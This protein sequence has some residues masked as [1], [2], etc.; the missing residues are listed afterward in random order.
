LIGANLVGRLGDSFGDFSSIK[1]ITLSNNLI[2]GN[3]PTNLPATLI[4]VFL[5]DN[6]LTG[7]IPSSISSLTQ[8]S[9]MSLN[10]NGL[11]GEIPD[12]F[13]DL[14]VLVN[15]DL[16]SNNLSGQLPSSMQKLSSLT[17]LHLQNNQISGTL[18]VL[19][20]LSLKDLNVENNLFNGPIPSPVES[21]PNFR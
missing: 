17:T 20:N 18:D 9:A 2:Q 16:S 14:P 15:L 11:S 3:I 8:L 5:S 4:N 6:K 13:G 19:Q 7:S 1:Y 10:D 21:I 12:A